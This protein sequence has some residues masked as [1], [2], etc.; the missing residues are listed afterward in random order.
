MATNPPNNYHQY[1]YVGRVKN[2]TGS[3]FENGYIQNTTIK[4]IPDPVDPQ[5]PVTLQY[6][7]QYTQTY[8]PYQ[9]IQLTGTDWVDV[10]LNIVPW[11]GNRNVIINGTQENFPNAQWQIAR[12]SANDQSVITQGVYSPMDGQCVL[13]IRW[14]PQTLLQIRKTT[15]DFDGNYEIS[16]QR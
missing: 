10:S 9:I 7:M 8:T 13:Q 12:S 4:T 15:G 16:I 14:L 1:G 3:T 5:D 2:T 6:L 11:Y